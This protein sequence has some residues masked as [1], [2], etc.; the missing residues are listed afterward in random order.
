MT[1]DQMVAAIGR[2]FSMLSDY[3]RGRATHTHGVAARGSL[4]VT[5]NPQFPQ[6]PLL[7][8][9]AKLDV[10]LRHGSVKGLRDDAIWDAR[11]AALRILPDLEP[12]QGSH[13]ILMNTGEVFP[14]GTASAF[15]QWFAAS[16]AQ[17]AQMVTADPTLAAAI[18]DALRDADTFINLRYHS[19][20]SFRFE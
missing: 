12:G 20:V 15:F 9:G 2:G 4:V 16:Q 3:R 13:D 10:V 11:G 8:A 17:R 5:Q 7:K 18:A 1:F 14:T 19:Q 6:N